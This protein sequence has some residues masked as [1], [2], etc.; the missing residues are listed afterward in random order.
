LSA[1]SQDRDGCRTD[2]PLLERMIA[3]MPNA[4]SLVSASDGTILY[5]NETWNRMFG[6]AS[7][8]AVGRHLSA[9]SLTSDENLPGERLREITGAIARSGSWTGDVQGLRKDGVL[10]WCTETIWQFDDEQ[11]ARIWVTVYGE[12]SFSA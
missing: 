1:T 12:P 8:E 9:V 10:F 5:T 11:G 7:G 2:A 4:L 6:Y 3:L